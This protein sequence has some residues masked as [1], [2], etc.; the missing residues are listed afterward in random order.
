MKKKSTVNQLVTHK[1][2]STA[3]VH[4]DTD[5][6]TAGLPRLKVI[7]SVDLQSSEA[8]SAFH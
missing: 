3:G 2:R 8:I 4:T 6:P 7:L 1:S 5:L